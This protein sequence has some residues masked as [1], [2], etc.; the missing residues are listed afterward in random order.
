MWYLVKDL[1]KLLRK[2][3][4]III[5]LGPDDHNCAHHTPYREKEHGDR[6]VEEISVLG[7]NGIGIKVL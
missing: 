1:V 3:V 4:T 7:E 2:D 5:N 6:F